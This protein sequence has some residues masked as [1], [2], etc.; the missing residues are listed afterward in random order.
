MRSSLGSWLLGRM[1]RTVTTTTMRSSHPQHYGV[2]PT[3]SVGNLLGI[4]FSVL[5]LSRTLVHVR[6]QIANRQHQIKR[7]LVPCA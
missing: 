3:F 2:C 6:F 7:G 4:L 5:F 1:L